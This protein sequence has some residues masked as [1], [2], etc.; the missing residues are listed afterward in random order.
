MR[1][2]CALIALVVTLFAQSFLASATTVPTPIA[3]GKSASALSTTNALK[4]LK[5]RLDS[6]YV[7][8]RNLQRQLACYQK[9]VPVNLVGETLNFD[10]SSE[11]HVWIEQTDPS[12]P[13]EYLVAYNK[14][15]VEGHTNG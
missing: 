14:M 13:D 10:T 6:H 7:M 5:L 15:C 11:H 3:V 12:N 1:I 2:Q 9:A 4:K 8:I